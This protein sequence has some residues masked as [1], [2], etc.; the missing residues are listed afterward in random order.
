[1]KGVILFPFLQRRVEGRA[2][3]AMAPAATVGVVPAAGTVAEA[4]VPRRWPREVRCSNFKCLIYLDCVDRCVTM[5]SWQL[6][7]VC[8]RTVGSWGAQPGQFRHPRG[9]ALTPHDA[10]LLV[11]DAGN[12]RVVVL[13]ATDG[14]WVRQLT[15][16]PGTLSHPSSVSVVPSTG[17]VLVLDFDRHHVF[18]FRSIEDDAVVGTLGTG[19]G[20]GPTQFQY[21][22][23]LA[24]LDGPCC[25]VVRFVSILK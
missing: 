7:G 21:P 17:Q 8:D 22:N 9:L 14:T 4:V 11:A 16:P 2:L 3:R 6:Q 15:G 1:M 13:R 18:Q 10:F 19:K 24:V 12:R 5:F 20:S 23:G 25:S